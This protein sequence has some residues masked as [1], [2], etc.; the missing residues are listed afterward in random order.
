VNLEDKTFRRESSAGCLAE[1]VTVIVAD[2]LEREDILR[3][4]KKTTERLLI[5]STVD[6]QMICLL[7]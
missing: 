6:T 3:V 5:D 7:T 1:V 4:S 2:L